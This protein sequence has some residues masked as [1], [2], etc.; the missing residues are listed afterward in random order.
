MMYT[1]FVARGYP[2]DKYK[3]YGIFEFDQ[4]KALA[5]KGVKVVYAAIDLR[6][7]RR[8]RSWGIHQE[9]IHGVEVYSINIPIGRFP[10]DSLRKIY[11]WGL[12]KLYRK[13]EKEQGRPDIIHSH[14]TDLS[15]AASSLREKLKLPLVVTEHSSNINKEVI[16]RDLFEAARVAYNKADKVIAVSEALRERISTNFNIDSLYI[17]NMVDLGVFKYRRKKETDSFNFVSTGNLIELKRMDLT[18]EAFYNVFKDKK[19]VSLKIFGQGTDKEKLHSLIKTLGLESRVKLMGLCSRDDIAGALAESDCFVLASRSETFG[20]AYI[21][22]L[23]M[24]VPVIATRCGGPEGFI[25]DGNGRLVPIDDMDSLSESMKYMYENR[26]AFD[27]EK[28][29]LETKERFSS[30]SIGEKLIKVY[31][32]VLR[33]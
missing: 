6:S 8:W 31:N 2:T 30:D 33:K 22:A 21:E 9:E 3:T 18:I 20:V 25:N 19:D 7:I 11:I 29:V 26:D 14:F 27:S 5:K 4:A 17:P 32:E 23:A 28:I 10:K 1:L 15:Y 13:I 24:G 16:D 12:G